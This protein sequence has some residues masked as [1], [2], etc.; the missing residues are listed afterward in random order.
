MILIDRFIVD[1]SIDDDSIVEDREIL[2]QI[3]RNLNLCY[4]H[5]L[6][7]FNEYQLSQ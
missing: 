3:S 4:Q 7:S 1:D 6:N 2:W 5:Q